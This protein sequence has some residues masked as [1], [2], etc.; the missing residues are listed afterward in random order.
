LEQGESRT[1]FLLRFTLSHPGMHTT[2]VGT[3]NPAHMA[4]NAAA[5]SK[6]G[7]ANDVYA[8]AKKRLEAAGEISE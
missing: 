7:L 6:G 4:Q 2:I 1:D 8:E 3:L 5:A